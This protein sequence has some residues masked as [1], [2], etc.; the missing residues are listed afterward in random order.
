ML[1]SQILAYLCRG[2][3]DHFFSLP[4]SDPDLLQCVNVP[5]VP[6]AD[7]LKSYPGQI[8]D[9]MICL[10]FPEGGKDSCQVSSVN[11]MSLKKIV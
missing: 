11:L 10:G 1:L 6:A 4:A 2:F 3:K 7:C 8:T 9:N 5:V